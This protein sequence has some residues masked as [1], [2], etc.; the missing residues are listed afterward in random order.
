MVEVISSTLEVIA[1][2][3]L[4]YGAL[5]AATVVVALVVDIA[6]KVWGPRK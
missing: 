3:V 5:V 4:I 1:T 2:V 6:A